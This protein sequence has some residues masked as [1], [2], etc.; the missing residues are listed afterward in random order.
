MSR[1]LLT[2]FKT[3]LSVTDDCDVNCYKLFEQL[4]ASSSVILYHNSDIRDVFK[5][6]V[7]RKLSEVY[8]N[9]IL[10]RIT[11]APAER[12]VSRLKLMKT[13]VRTTVAQERLTGLAILSTENEVAS[14]LH[15]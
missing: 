2:D 3:V 15:C 12:S 14:A 6:I 10:K 13:Q 4:Q 7:E 11:T 1:E 5:L 8:P 9:V